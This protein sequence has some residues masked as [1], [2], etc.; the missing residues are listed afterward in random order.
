M[1]LII[2]FFLTAS[3]SLTLPLAST[4][5]TLGLWVLILAF[6][7]ATSISLPLSSW[8]RFILFII[9]IG[10]LLVIFAY[11]TAID[12]NSKLD[13][14]NLIG[15]TLG[16]M[17]VL[18]LIF[19]STSLS[20]LSTLHAPY[21]ISFSILFSSKNIPTLLIAAIVL[22]LALIR[23]VKITQRKEGPLRPFN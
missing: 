10:G 1:S 21:L 6:I 18:T 11:F 3:I 2:F 17:L 8:F 13:L 7:V 12:P 9:Y 4:P 14:S 16:T 23:V 20:A 15:I 5:L 19:S 22:F